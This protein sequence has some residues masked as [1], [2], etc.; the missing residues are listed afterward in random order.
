MLLCN[1]GTGFCSLLQSM[2]LQFPTLSLCSEWFPAVHRVSPCHIFSFHKKITAEGTLTI[3]SQWSR[4]VEMSYREENFSVGTSNTHVGHWVNRWQPN[5]IC[6]TSWTQDTF[7]YNFWWQWKCYS[8]TKLNIF[9]MLICKFLLSC[10][11]LNIVEVFLTSWSHVFHPAT[12]RVS[13]VIFQSR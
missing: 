13:P 9:Y 7:T 1:K 4:E 3:L 11:L 5:V 10:S 6:S 2:S 12:R 8:R